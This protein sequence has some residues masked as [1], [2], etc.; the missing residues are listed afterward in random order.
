MPGE[1]EGATPGG[2]G[3]P[4]DPGVQG[5]HRAGAHT[6]WGHVDEGQVGVGA[7]GLPGCSVA[8]PISGVIVSDCCCCNPRF[9]AFDVLVAFQTVNSIGSFTTTL[10]TKIIIFI[11]VTLVIYGH[12]LYQLPPQ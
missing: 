1:G 2:G 9:V 6:A 10:M 7:R 3:P 4:G 11:S 5:L 12:Y 8:S